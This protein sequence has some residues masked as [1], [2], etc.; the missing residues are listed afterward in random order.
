MVRIVTAS[1]K[2]KSQSSNSYSQS[3]RP[4]TQHLP[5]FYT[6]L[7]L[8]QPA[9]TFHTLSVNYF[10]VYIFIYWDSF[11]FFLVKD[12]LG[13]LYLIYR[14]IYIQ[15]DKKTRWHQIPS[16]IHAPYSFLEW[17]PP[18]P[19]LFFSF[20]LYYWL[21]HS[22]DVSLISCFSLPTLCSYVWNDCVVLRVC[23]WRISINDEWV[24]FSLFGFLLMG[25]WFWK[26]EFWVIWNVLLLFFF[27]FLAMN[28]M[29]S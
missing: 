4:P 26:L 24:L 16:K 17:V 27:S 1:E 28:F 7:F 12:L 9:Q 5:L 18:L 10:K 29:M 6:V 3:Y 23:L 14:Y 2:D 19:L 11:S 21:F 20:S 22:I 15:V 25:Y 8:K 13:F